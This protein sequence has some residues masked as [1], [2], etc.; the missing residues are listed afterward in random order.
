MRTGFRLAICLAAVLLTGCTNSPTEPTGE[1]KMLLR[2]QA[3]S[4]IDGAMLSGVAVQVGNERAVTTDGS[5]SF[6]VELSGPGSYATTIR[7][8]NV[9]ERHTRVNAAST[10][11]RFGP[12]SSLRPTLP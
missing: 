9:V 10:V 8:A 2:G 4:A 6:D 3:V 7:G 5:G 11:F 1:S 12:N